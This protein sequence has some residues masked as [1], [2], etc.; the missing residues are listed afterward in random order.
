MTHHSS[1][2]IYGWNPD[3]STWEDLGFDEPPEGYDSPSDWLEEG[4]ELDE[5]EQTELRM[6]AEMTDDLSLIVEQIE[7]KMEK[8]KA[9]R[10]TAEYALKAAND[11]IEGAH[12]SKEA[13][14]TMYELRDAAQLL[15]R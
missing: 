3:D 11:M 7:A 1:I 15:L 8:A 6:I 5:G 12:L 10:M 4:Q 2:G 9:I 14:P 13:I